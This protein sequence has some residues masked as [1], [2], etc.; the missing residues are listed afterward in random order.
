MLVSWKGLLS[1]LGWSKHSNHVD[2]GP[3]PRLKDLLMSTNLVVALLR[4]ALIEVLRSDGATWNLPSTYQFE[5]PR[6]APFHRHPQNQEPR[7]HLIVSNPC[8]GLL[9]VAISEPTNQIARLW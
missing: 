1:L 6:N 4:F 8:F 2:V 3:F 9:S 5:A 7:Y